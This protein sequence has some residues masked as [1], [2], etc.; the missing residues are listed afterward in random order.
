MSSLYKRKSDNKWV[1]VIELPRKPG[2]KRNR[3]PFYADGNLTEAQA[4]KF[5]KSKKIELEYQIENNIYR[6]SGNATIK[7]LVEE[8]NKNN[9]DIA[10]TTQSLHNMY[11]K[12]HIAPEKGGIGYV[13][14]KDA[15]PMVFENFYHEK[16]QDKK[17]VGRNGENKI[18]KGLSA[19]TI[20]KLHSF[21]HGAFKFAIKNKMMLTNPLDATKCPKKVKFIP[22]I[23]TDEEFMNLLESVRGTMDEVVIVLAGVLS[24]C[25]GEIFGLRW[26]NIDWKN[27]KIT[28]NE[29]Y[30]RFDKY[31]RKP[32]KADARTRT[33]YA[34]KFVF[35]I[36]KQYKETLDNADGYVFTEYLP[37]SY[38]KRFK[39]LV[40]K[41]NLKGVT[42]HK[43]R[44]YN[45]VIM[46]KLGI[47]DKIAAGRTGHSQVATLQ[48][49]YQHVTED[50]DKMA[51]DKINE[52][53]NV[54]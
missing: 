25:R 38:S 20:I 9:K 12:K 44:H 5:F 48:E 28:V 8:Y 33:I 34:P 41:F 17:I 42:L 26:S 39:V 37:D 19:N 35:D 31:V 21:L 51:S 54:H 50:A 22:R 18:K 23:P 24:L 49:V 29:T 15:L 46:M 1:C 36:L 14:L 4:I 40:E 16:M 3:K 7:D 47:P 13:K 30:V 52:F 43:L 45:A 6:N 53:F 27:S 10:V 11:V 2:E 32:P